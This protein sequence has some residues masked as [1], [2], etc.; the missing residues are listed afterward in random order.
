VVP[1]PVAG[2]A[3]AALRPYRESARGDGRVTL[4]CVASGADLDDAARQARDAEAYLRAHA[5]VLAELRDA[6]GAG[7]L[8]VAV[9]LD[10]AA[11]Q[12]GV[13]FP[14]ALATLAG[15]LGLALV[16]SVYAASAAADDAG[17]PAVIAD[18][19]C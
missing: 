3:R 15:E 9:A 11:A 2:A 5:A 7:E 1:A 8:D 14:P 6:G 12:A 17:P 18:P 10:A 13:R 19:R 16:A 4:H